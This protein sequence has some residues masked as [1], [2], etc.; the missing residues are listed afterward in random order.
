MTN[1]FGFAPGSIA[2]V[3]G[4]RPEIVKLAHI[5]RLLGD[6]ARIVH[7]GQHYD[8]NL[9]ETFFR[10]MDL[11]SPELFLQVG[12]TSRGHQIGEGVK[13]L[14]GYLATNRPQAIL[15]QGD[16]N[17]VTAG[18]LAANSRSIFLGHIEA[19]LRS[20]DRA[21]PE[22]HNR[23][24]TDHLSDLCCAPTQTSVEN[25]LSE[26]IA[27]RRIALTGNTVVEAVL[28]LLPPPEER[29][30]ILARYELEPGKFALS[31]FHRPENVDDRDRFAAIL[32]QLADLPVPVVLPLHPRSVA[33]AEEFGFGPLLERIRVEKPIGYRDFLAL[34]AE[35]AVMVSDSGG[36]AEE[37]SVVKRPLVVVRNS[38][39]RPEVMGTFAVRVGAGPAI[40]VEARRWL[41]TGW[42]ELEAVPSP[43]G[44]GT[45]SEKSLEAMAERIL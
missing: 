45:A 1:Q 15:V 43:Y 10:E 33:R 2:V 23:V 11:P 13:A 7:T 36:I 25:L 21:M 32:E 34:E 26:G 38:T 28:H 12:G 37:A 31:T 18:A 41:E 42:S 39:E 8:P 40:G 4:T 35:S 5:I 29:L 20:R 19:G 22:E 16:T 14:D 24:V 44:D 6:G 30:E 3:L 17:A 27:Q 9:S